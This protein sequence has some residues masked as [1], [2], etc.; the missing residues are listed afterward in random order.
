MLCPVWGFDRVARTCLFIAKL[1]VFFL[2]KDMTRSFFEL[3]RITYV[4]LTRIGVPGQIDRE[5]RQDCSY[6][7][8]FAPN[9]R[10]CP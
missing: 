10:L 8:P 9:L 3:K 4:F 1:K 5:S 7:R 2:S 6:E